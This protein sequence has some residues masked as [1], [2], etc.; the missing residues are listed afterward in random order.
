M[1]YLIPFLILFTSIAYADDFASRA[2]AGDDAAKTAQ[3]IKY[4]QSIGSFI[5]EAMY[6]CILSQPHNPADPEKF[7]L[8][9][10][11]NMTGQL[12]NVEVNP[13]FKASLCFSNEFP[14]NHFPVPPQENS[15][16]AGYPLT[17]TVSMKKP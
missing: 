15:T 5:G 10:F 2:K 12:T 7:T 4:Q 17:V 8:I 14:K 11:V 13:S 16:S 3:G 6:T 1:K 9:A